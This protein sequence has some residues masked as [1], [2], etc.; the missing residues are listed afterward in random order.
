[1]NSQNNMNSQPNNMNSQPPFMNSCQYCLKPTT[2][3]ECEACKWMNLYQQANLQLSINCPNCIVYRCLDHE[4]LIASLQALNEY[5]KRNEFKNIDQIIDVE[6]EIKRDGLLMNTVKSK[7]KRD[8]LDQGCVKQGK[9]M[10]STIEME[11]D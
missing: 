6:L 4:F 2:K 10:T 3:T 1:M 9:F 11:I 8:S 5:L 7:R